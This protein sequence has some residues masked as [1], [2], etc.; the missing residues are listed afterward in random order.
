MPTLE[1][2]QTESREDLNQRLEAKTLEM[3]IT[4]TFA[5]YLEQMET[6]LLQLEQRVKTLETRMEKTCGDITP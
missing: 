2:R 1:E 6:Y 5:Q 3:G 4:H